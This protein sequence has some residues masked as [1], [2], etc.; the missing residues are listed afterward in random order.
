[1]TS[2]GIGCCGCDGKINELKSSTPSESRISLGIGGSE[3]K[4]S[5]LSSS[6]YLD[7]SELKYFRVPSIIIILQCS[8]LDV[9]RML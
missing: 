7:R 9:W 8:V 5:K 1:M 4:L 3:R 2:L 6:L